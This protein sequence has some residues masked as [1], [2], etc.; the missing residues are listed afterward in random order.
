LL[1]WLL[2]VCKSNI[3]TGRTFGTFYGLLR[4]RPDT[5]YVL[6]T[7]LSRF[8]FS[9]RFSRPRVVHGCQMVWFPTK[10][11]NLGKFWRVLHWKM[12]VCFMDTTVFCYILWTFDTVRGN[13]V[14]FSLFWFFVPRK[15]WQPW[16]CPEPIK[17]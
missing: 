5:R 9:S 7:P 4:N 15:I 17:M 12:M 1:S 3:E 10:N 14:Y 16:C 8:K 2:A 6:W 11:P 13:L